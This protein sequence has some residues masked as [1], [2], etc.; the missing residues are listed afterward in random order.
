MNI[1]FEIG[2]EIYFLK[3]GTNNILKS[4]ITR[5]VVEGAVQ[6]G[7]IILNTCR[8]TNVYTKDAFKTL[9]D[10]KANIIKNLAELINKV[11]SIKEI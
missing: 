3:E 2:Q 11:S 4:K 1:D 10:A 5:M 6:G 8:G 9:E 7:H